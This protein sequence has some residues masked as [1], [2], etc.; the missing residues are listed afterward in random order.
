MRPSLLCFENPSV[1]LWAEGLENE[2]TEVLW[3]VL[4]D[5]ALAQRAVRGKE[6]AVIVMT[7]E[8]ARDRG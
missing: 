1:S 7:S 4:A 2:T 3:A 6:M 5:E 8:L